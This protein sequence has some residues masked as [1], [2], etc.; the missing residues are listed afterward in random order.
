MSNKPFFSVVVPCHNAAATIGE[1]LQRLCE[2]AFADWEAIIL[3]DGSADETPAI[4]EGIASRDSRIQLICQ[5]NTGVSK[6]RNTGASLAKGR[7]LAFLDSDDLWHVNYLERMASHLAEHPEIGISFAT[8]RIVDSEGKPTGSFSSKKSRDLTIGDFLNG[9]P[10]TTCSNL[11]VSRTIFTQLGGF[12]ED[13]CH[14]EDQLFLLRAHLAGMVVEGVDDILVDY[15]INEEGL[16][17]DLE[18]MRQGWE[19]MAAY[20]LKK[21]PVLIGPLI[22]RA[23]ALNLAYLARRALRVRRNQNAWLYMRNALRSDWTILLSRPWPN[24]PLS[25]AC[26]L[27][28]F[29]H[30]GGNIVREKA[31]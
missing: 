13:I 27:S 12:P 3:D 22:P 11:I 25:A 24:V 19:H 10:T 26:F 7:Y 4:V 20:A 5:E 28:G 18:S 21:Q 30:S 9:N 23:R 29:T 31:L 16:S 14:A 15:R 8:A 6:T 17:A 1:T 2:Q